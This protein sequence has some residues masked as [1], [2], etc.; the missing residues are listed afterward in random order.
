[1]TNVMGGIATVVELVI[2]I[3]LIIGYKTKYAA[4]VASLLTLTFILF[5]STSIGVQRPINFGVFTATTASFLLF[6]ISILP[7]SIFDT[8]IL[9]KKSPVSVDADQLN[10]ATFIINN[11]VSK[12]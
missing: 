8:V 11:T 4:L 7:K 9:V 1:M 5:M 12:R 10:Q 2:A 6:S 3:L